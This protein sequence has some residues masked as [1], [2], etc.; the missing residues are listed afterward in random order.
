MYGYATA[1]A[2]TEGGIHADGRRDSIW[3]VFSR[4]EGKI[5]DGSTTEITN[6]AY[7]RAEDDVELLRQLG[8]TGYRFSVSWSRIIPL[9]EHERFEH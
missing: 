4:Q 5:E 1:A 9:G 7:H 3:D 2:Q 8:A 6:D